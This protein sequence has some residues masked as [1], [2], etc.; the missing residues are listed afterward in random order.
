MNVN[1]VQVPG[2]DTTAAACCMNADK[3]KVPSCDVTAPA[4]CINAAT[5]Q[6][7]G[8]DVRLHDVLQLGLLIRVMF[9]IIF[10]LNMYVRPTHFSLFSYL[11]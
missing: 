5:D 9:I 8:C 10:V 4:C 2:C 3:E 7:P 6:V 1:T 11:I